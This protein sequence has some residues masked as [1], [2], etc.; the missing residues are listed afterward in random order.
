M[1]THSALRKHEVIRIRGTNSAGWDRTAGWGNELPTCGPNEKGSALLL[2]KF[3][4]VAELLPAAGEALDSWVTS[5]PEQRPR[6]RVR[7]VTRPPDRPDSVPPGHGAAGSPGRAGELLGE[8]TFIEELK[9][10]PA[11]NWTA[12]FP[13][14][15]LSVI[16]FSHHSL[17]RPQ[18]SSPGCHYPSQ[19]RS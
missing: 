11:K 9:L 17:P 7:G 5:L 6:H 15:D 3:P 12:L 13:L 1:K 14:A 16:L 10:K 8:E 2:G 18:L 19:T 4:A